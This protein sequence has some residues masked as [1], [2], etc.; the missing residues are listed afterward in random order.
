MVRNLFD[1]TGK[2]A[3]ITGGTKGIGY[4]IANAF[5]DHGATIV[6][7][8]RTADAVKVVADEINQRAG[9]NA[10]SGVVA[11]LADVAQTLAAYDQAVESLG[12]VD[13]L[14]CNAAALPQ[15]F[16][17][18]DQTDAAEYARLVNVN[19]VN[20]AALMNHAAVDMKARRDGDILVTT[21]ASGVR[22]SFGVLAYGV[23]KAGLN[24]LVRGLGAELA[25]YNIRV[26]GVSPGLTRTAAMEER[27]RQ[28]PEWIESLTAGIPLGRVVEPEEIAAGMVFLASAGGKSMAGQILNIDGGEPGTGAPN[29]G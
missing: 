27:T 22:P 10:A 18:A 3:F 4:A 12:R 8:S 14:V 20:N 1:L 26:N 7:T 23:S 17:P 11:D 5:V 6:F 24:F 19:I 13:V 9:R 25:P 28:D 29:A 21:S 16:G 15:T 2:T